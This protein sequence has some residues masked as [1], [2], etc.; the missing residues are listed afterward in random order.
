M[1]EPGRHP[2]QLLYDFAFRFMLGFW[3][4]LGLLDLLKNWVAASNAGRPFDWPWSL[5][6][7][8]LYSLAWGLISPAIYVAFKALL[9]ASWA[10]RFVMHG[11]LS[12]TFGGLHI[13]LLS[14]CFS[15]LNYVANDI[16]STFWSYYQGR[17]SGRFYPGWLD[18]AISYC[19][20][21]IILLGFDYYERFRHQATL[22]L[23]LE[24]QLSQAQLQTLRMQIQPHF[25][26]NAHNT[27]AMLVRRGRH[28]AAVD[29]I[30]GLSDMLRTSL[31]RESQ[32]LIPLHEE[33]DLAEKY[34]NIER[35][36]FE[37]RLSVDI[38]VQPTIRD[39]LVPNLILQPLIENAIKHGI[40]RALS[41]G[42]LKISARATG[43]RLHLQV[44]NSGP[45]LPE[46]WRIERC[47]GIGLRNVTQ[48]L[49]KLYGNECCFELTNCENGV[50][51]EVYIP[52]D[53]QRKEA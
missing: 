33:V 11:F 46:D 6:F 41:G 22:A 17:T 10:K 32:Q 20:V 25:L 48:R 49:E 19:M 31:T 21:V 50:A 5:A 38:E 26:F 45:H 24:S 23:Q 47:E 16:N 42:S 7:V 2:G 53:F 35:A 28:N 29:M 15:F 9:S 36:R 8:A 34:L 13:L 14:I 39:A 44:W 37:D 27:I 52:L 18:S 1:T 3:V 4:L 43:N 30:S 51:A 40:G 12:V